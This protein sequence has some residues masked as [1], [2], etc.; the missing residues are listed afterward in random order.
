MLWHLLLIYSLSYDDY[1]TLF[2]FT[3]QVHPSIY[4]PLL[5]DVFESRGF[6]VHPSLT[7][8]TTFDDADIAT[9]TSHVHRLYFLVTCDDDTSWNHYK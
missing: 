4:Y 1:I 3:V 9:N 6:C 2:L 8:L 5:A 7:S